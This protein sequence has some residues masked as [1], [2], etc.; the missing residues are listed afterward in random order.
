MTLQFKQRAREDI[1][2]RRRSREQETRRDRREAV[3]IAA[4]ART[5]R[6]DILPTCPKENRRLDQLKPADRKIRKL[7]E[8]QI[9]RVVASIQTFGFVTPI[10]IDA[11]GRIIDGHTRAEAAKRLGLT[12]APCLVVDHLSAVELNALKIAINRTAETGVWD[13]PAL[14]LELGELVFEG[15][16]VELTG[17]SAPEID[18]LLPAETEDAAPT[19]RADPVSKPGDVWVLKAHRL[20]C[21]SALERASYAALMGDDVARL[22]LTDEPYNVPIAGHVTSGE[23]REFAMAAGEMSLD[24]FG[25]FNLTWMTL[26]IVYLMQGGMLGTFIDWRSIDLVIRTGKLL[27]L[28]LLNLIVWEKT[29]AGMGS[30]WRSQH[31][32]LPMFKKGGAPHINN[33]ELGKHGRN[34]SNVWTYPGANSLGSS[35]H[36][37]LADH[38]TP[39]PVPMLQDALLD[40][41]VRGDIVLDP[42]LGSGSMLI[43]AEATGRRCR[44]IE[45]DPLYVDLAVR[46]WEAH[47]GE[48]A[49]LEQSGASFSETAVVRSNANVAA[50][51][52]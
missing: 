26:C 43:A 13:L 42:F 27:E 10:L 8:A 44:G 41:T 46:R 15:F 5:P 18:A 25:D 47:T 14:E 2:E 52:R 33:I 23:H 45:L 11:D 32:L 50:E 7:T 22:V 51:V 17:F 16:A 39:K 21:G 34:R 6:N 49:F 1:R 38:P 35:A 24:Q 19:L 40:V 48:A 31:E 12:E 9:A 30:L 28:E 37:M 4:L 3:D 36:E 29:N 20:L